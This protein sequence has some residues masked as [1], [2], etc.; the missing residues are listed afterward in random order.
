GRSAATAIDRQAVRRCQAWRRPE[1]TRP[2]LQAALDRTALLQCAAWP[3]ARQRPRP[4]AEIAGAVGSWRLAPRQAHSEYR[5]FARLAR[6][7]HVAAHHARE[8]AG[9][10]EAEP[11]AAVAARRQGIGLGEILKK[12]CQL[13][14]CHT[15]AGIGNRKL[16]PVA[17]VRHLAHP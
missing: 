15:D 17:A 8:L 1:R 10:S 12:F 5:A 4:D 14:R 9:D 6:H 13:L 16:D 7:G 3:E 2:G 11:R